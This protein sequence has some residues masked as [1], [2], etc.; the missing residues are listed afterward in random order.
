VDGVQVVIELLGESEEVGPGR[1]FRPRGQ[2]TGSALSLLN[3][4]GAGLIAR[5]YLEVMVEQHRLDG[6][7][8]SRVAVRVANV[9]AYAVLKIQA[10]QDRH[11]NRDAYDLC[12]PSSTT[13]ADQTALARSLRPA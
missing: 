9:L 10:F 13:E 7:G 12:S 4:S 8:W 2:R 5:D 1:S 11:E 6:G 3:I